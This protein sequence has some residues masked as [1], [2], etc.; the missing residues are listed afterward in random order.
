MQIVSK[1]NANFSKR[2]K[3]SKDFY[4]GIEDKAIL[5]S[6]ILNETI[7]NEEVLLNENLIIPYITF[8]L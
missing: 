7:K 8:Y 3:I 6:T 1:Q 5:A 4:I 2:V